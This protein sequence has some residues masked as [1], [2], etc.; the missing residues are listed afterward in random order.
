MK[1]RYRN[2]LYLDATENIAHVSL[3][4]IE[5]RAQDLYI[6]GS[7]DYGSWYCCFEYKIGDSPWALLYEDNDQ[8]G[9]QI[10]DIDSCKRALGIEID[11]YEL[12][13]FI[14]HTLCNMK[15]E[16]SLLEEHFADHR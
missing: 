2:D 9:S 16:L 15:I 4:G 10:G 12:C 5:I 11:S 7:N 1:P 3:G 6:T 13:T 8:K 14:I